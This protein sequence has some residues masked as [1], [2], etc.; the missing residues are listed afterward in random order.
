MTRQNLP[1]LDGTAENA[2][3][4]VNKGAYIISEAKGDLDGIIIAT[5]SEVKLALDTQAALEAEGV[6]VRVVSMSSQNL[7]DEQDAA[8]KEEVLPAAVTKRLAIEL[9]LALVGANT[10]VLQVKHL[11]LILGVPQHL[12]TVSLKNMVSL[13]KM[14]VNFTNHCKKRKSLASPSSFL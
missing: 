12:V 14:Q 11:L 3:A 13:L 5:G 10:L 6:H 4:G 2:E 8:Y 7:F 9:E 1:V